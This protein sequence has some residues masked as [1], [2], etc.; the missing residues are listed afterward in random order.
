[1][2]GFSE[3]GLWATVGPR[4]FSNMVKRFRTIERG[5]GYCER[6]P[7]LNIQAR[8]MAVDIE[9]CVV[10]R[11]AIMTRFAVVSF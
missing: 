2:E 5:R 11:N 1:M 6:L 7:V 8:W 10:L 9:T 4:I 3:P